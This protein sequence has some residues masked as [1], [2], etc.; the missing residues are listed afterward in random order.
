MAF[1]GFDS[2][3]FRG[4][5]NNHRLTVTNAV[6]TGI[7]VGGFIYRSG[8]MLFSETYA[9][10]QEAMDDLARRAR[11]H[12]FVLHMPQPDLGDPFS[13]DVEAF[14]RDAVERVETGYRLDD[15]DTEAIHVIVATAQQYEDLHHAVIQEST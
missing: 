5:E 14:I 1:W 13:P 3:V 8:A 9:T 11:E 12:D 7:G 10:I 4:E 15:A 2:D 6:A